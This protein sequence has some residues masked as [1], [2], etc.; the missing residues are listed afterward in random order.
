MVDFGN[1]HDN[2]QTGGSVVDVTIKWLTGASI[3]AFALGA[4][5]P[6]M[7]SGKADFDYAALALSVLLYAGAVYLAKN[8]E[9][10]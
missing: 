7:L 3:A 1:G 9:E 4:L 2:F 10:K 8:E 6:H 5:K